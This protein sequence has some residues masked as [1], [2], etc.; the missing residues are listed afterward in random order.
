MTLIYVTPFLKFQ[1]LASTGRTGHICSHLVQL[2]AKFW[3]RHV[4]TMILT[5]TNR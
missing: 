5:R 3:G 4:N 2:M 1:P